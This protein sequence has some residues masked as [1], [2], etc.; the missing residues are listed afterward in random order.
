VAA[1]I[2]VSEGNY[3]I[4]QLHIEQTMN[5]ELNPGYKWFSLQD[6]SLDGT[7]HPIDSSG[8]LQIGWWGSTLSDEEGVI[9]PSPTITIQEARLIHTLQ[10]A[11]DSELEEFPVDFIVELYNEEYLLYTET[12]VGNTE[13]LWKKNLNEVYD[14]T[15]IIISISKVNKEGRSVKII[16]TFSPFEIVRSDSLVVDLIYTPPPIYVESSDIL[17]ID[18]NIEAYEIEANIESLD[19]IFVKTDEQTYVNNVHS[20]MDATTRHVYG[21]VEITYTN[22]LLNEQINIDANQ[23]NYATHIEELADNITKAKYKWFS[24]HDN[25]LDG[26]YHPIPKNKKYSVG[27][28][29]TELSKEDGT[30][31]ENPLIIVTFTGRSLMSLKVVGDD[32]L[33]CYPIDFTIQ[34]FDDTDTLLYTESVVD[35]NVIYWR[36]EIDT[37]T[38]VTKMTLEISKINK[39]NSVAKITEFYTAV[40]ETYDEHMIQS[41]HLLEETGY[42][43]GQLPIG[44][45]SS[46]EIDIDLNNFDGR[47]NINNTE[48]AL[49][50]LLKRNRRVRVWF[51]VEIIPNE[52]EWYLVGKFW[53]VSWNVPE[54]SFKASLTAR[55]R[56]DMLRYTEFKTSEVY[57]NWNLYQL[58][59]LVLQDAG[60]TTDDYVLDE[61]L[62]DV[63]IPY[64][65]FNKMSHRNALS[66]LSQCALVQVFCDRDGKIDV[67]MEMEGIS[68]VMMRYDDDN[69]FDSSHPS[70]WN[71]LVNYIEVTAQPLTLKE[72]TVIYVDEETI[73][74]GA[75]ESITL[76]HVFN[77]IPCLN[78]EEPTITADP[79]VI[80]ENYEVYAWGVVA[81]YKNTDSSSQSITK[82]EI[83][84]RPLIAEGKSIHVAKDDRLIHDDGMI[85]QSH[86]HP[87]IQ[88]RQYAQCLAGKIL[89]LYKN[90]KSDISLQTRGHITL[91]LGDNIQVTTKD[92]AP[93]K[94]MVTR[95]TTDWDGALSGTLEGIKQ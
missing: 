63:I 8:T 12:V 91:R 3:A 74:I 21:K 66:Q 24:L 4:S 39:A 14:V 17:C 38:N 55:D 80:V 81:T 57:Q 92:N 1:I 46:N 18:G 26:S 54:N 56:L 43:T 60:L 33:N 85:K 7:Y 6:N 42:E 36:K 71:Q 48:S 35:N 62:Q 93:E 67:L 27:W 10:I 82:I 40:I 32:L 89:S 23:I 73:T 34:V 58:F 72:T 90:S 69:V 45:I 76:E 16:S 47:F 65:W 9:T 25:R 28:W 79:S 44:N 86:E 49:Y 13:V 31:D 88:S 51:G 30:F 70:A 94:Y 50:G 83:E 41:I 75:G 95:Q 59:E 15:D 29:G 61:D 84:G 78:I 5:Q 19:T 77:N 64:A 53:T 87:F 37:I 20:I 2:T 22:P 68:N 11:G 52:I